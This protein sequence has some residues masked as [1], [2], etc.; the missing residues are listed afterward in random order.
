MILYNVNIHLCIDCQFSIKNVEIIKYSVIPCCIHSL[1]DTG[2]KDYHVR[3]DN[4]MRTKR[5]QKQNK[6]TTATKTNEKVKIYLV[7]PNE[8]AY[9]VQL[10]LN[11]ITISV[12]STHKYHALYYL[13][14][15][16]QPS[17]ALLFVGKNKCSV[18]PLGR[19]K[20]TCIWEKQQFFRKYTGTCVNLQQ[21]IY[22]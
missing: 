5:I 2:K 14:I 16:D 4:I 15:C 8:T 19:C 1:L 22:M 17:A 21:I 3:C 18:V 9:T 11:F 7:Q 12:H 6:K 20:H 13:S 10:T